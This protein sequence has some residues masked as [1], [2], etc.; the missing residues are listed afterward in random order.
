MQPVPNLVFVYLQGESNPIDASLFQAPGPIN[1]GIWDCICTQAS[2][3][4]L[5]PKISAFTEGSITGTNPAGGS[6]VS[7]SAVTLTPKDTNIPW[8]FVSF[9]P[10]IHVWVATASIT[11]NG[12][13]YPVEFTLADV[14]N[15]EQYPNPFTDRN[16]DTSLGGPNLYLTLVDNTANGGSV[17]FD[18]RWGK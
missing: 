4:T 1:S 18:L 16:P 11:Y 7:M 15:R 6:P 10:T 17:G 5:I 13:S 9:D 3:Q 12:I 14:L 8:R 2:A